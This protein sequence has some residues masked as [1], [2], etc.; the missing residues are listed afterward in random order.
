MLAEPP[1][2]RLRA[3][4][5]IMTVIAEVVAHSWTGYSGETTFALRSEVRPT[6]TVKAQLASG[7]R[8]CLER[9][10]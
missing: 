9:I 2:T 5:G 3:N 10:K 1:C 4:A 7:Q 8:L 6:A